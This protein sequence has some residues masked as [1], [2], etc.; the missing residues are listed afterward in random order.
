[1]RTATILICATLVL[2]GCLA[3]GAGTGTGPASTDATSDDE[4]ANR[5]GN[6][7]S[8]PEGTDGN[9][10]GDGNLT[11]GETVGEGHIAQ[12]SPTA[13][14]RSVAVVTCHMTDARCVEGVDSFLVDAP[15]GGTVIGTNTTDNGGQGFNL[16]LFFHDASGQY[17]GGCGEGALDRTDGEQTCE[18][19]EGAATAVVDAVWGT[20]LDVV[21]EVVAPPGGS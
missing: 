21:V 5:T 6:R 4:P 9:A 1:M 19:P 17:L 2:A 7:S 13:W 11:E 12:G 20:D 3:G 18:V 15:P 8:R 10:T 16:N 14:Y